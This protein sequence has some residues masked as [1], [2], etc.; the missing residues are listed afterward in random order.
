MDALAFGIMLLLAVMA[1]LFLCL[2]LDAATREPRVVRRHDH[3]FP[4]TPLDT[5]ERR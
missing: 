4:A 2:W 1:T 5:S 3:L